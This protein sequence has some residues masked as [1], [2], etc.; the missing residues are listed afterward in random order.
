M[1]GAH[2]SALA[3]KDFPA[4]GKCVILMWRIPARSVAMRTTRTVVTALCLP[5]LLWCL[6]G[7]GLIDRLVVTR[8]EVK[9]A[10]RSLM[11]QVLGAYEDVVES[12]VF[13]LAGVRYVDPLTGDPSPPP[14]M[15]ASERRA[16]EARRTMEFNR[17]DVLLFERLG[18]VGEGRDGRLVFL[19]DQQARLRWQDPWL[20]GLVGDVTAD[21][22]ESRVGVV[23]R[24]VEITPELQDEGGEETVWGIL[25]VKHRQEAAAGTWIQLADGTWQR[26]SRE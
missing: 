2:K 3:E 24:L 23:Q 7:C 15:T 19:E 20:F 22:N 18:Y 14:E 26:K 8:I 4:G 25:A 21:E 16:L 12:E 1:R 5:A 11:E 6:A 13:L 9:S 17:D 10:R